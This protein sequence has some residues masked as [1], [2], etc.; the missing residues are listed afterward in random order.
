[1]KCG[2]C[3]CELGRHENGLYH[4]GRLHCA[5]CW[6]EITAIAPDEKRWQFR[7]GRP[8]TLIALGILLLVSLIPWFHF[9]FVLLPEA[10]R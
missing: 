10:L 2:S 8:D 1:M 9:L 7:P 3:D 6:E 4:A 5:R